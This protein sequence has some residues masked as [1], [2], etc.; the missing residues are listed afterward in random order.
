VLELLAQLLG[1]LRGVGALAVELVYEGDARDVVAAHLP[2]HGHGLRLDPGHA[3]QHQH[4]SVQ[5]AQR[6][7]DLDREIDVPG[8]VDDVDAV[9]A[10]ARVGRGGLDRD[11]ALALEVHGVHG[12][13]DP[14]LA[15]DLAH[16][17]DPARVEQDPLGQGGLPRVDVGADA[18]VAELREVVRM[19][20]PEEREDRCSD[21]AGLQPVAVKRELE[22][23]GGRT[24]L[25]EIRLTTTA[26]R[27]KGSAPDRVGRG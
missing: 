4:R 2:V 26:S 5:H 12:R 27:Q 9:V 8:R 15:L 10:P 18:D 20:I 3:A 25:C 23:S 7:L 21:R 1:H 13:A 19:W 17:M 22:E 16:L 11:A 24:S 6:A 14:V